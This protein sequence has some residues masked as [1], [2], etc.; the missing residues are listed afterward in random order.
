MNS[1]D[2]ASADVLGIVLLVLALCSAVA[3]FVARSFLVIAAHLVLIGAST[4]AA[5]LAGGDGRA[6]ALLLAVCSGWGAFI[7]VA[8]S[9]LSARTHGAVAVGA[10]LLPTLAAG[11]VLVTAASG[12]GALRLAPPVTLAS[13]SPHEGWIAVLLLVGGAGLLGVLGYG[14]RGA[15]EPRKGMGE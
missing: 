3:A 10:T 12:L 6:A 7:V 11:A 8:T 13:L 9:L 1:A 14:E 2:F 5:L 15:L 4:G